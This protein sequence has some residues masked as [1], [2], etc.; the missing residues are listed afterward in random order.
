M[1]PRLFNQNKLVSLIVFFICGLALIAHVVFFS[2]Y[3]VDDAYISYRYSENFADGNG[4]VFNH[5]EKVEGYSNFLWVLL[6]GLLKKGSVDVILASK[7]IGL[8]S[9]L[10]VLIAYYLIVRDLTE[11]PLFAAASLWLLVTNFGLVFFS[12]TGMET[13]FFTAFILW[14]GYIFYRNKSQLT[15][16]LSLISFGVALTR[17]EGILFFPVLVV[18]D[19]I[20]NKRLSGKLLA[21]TGVFTGLYA[22]FLFWRYSYYGAFF[23]NTYYAKLLKV[24]AGFSQ[25]MYGFDD[26]YRFIASTGGP[27]MFAIAVV[28]LMKKKTRE[29]VYALLP[30]LAV[31]LIFQIYS[32]G[33]WMDSYRFLVPMLPAYL[34]IGL[35]GLWWL[36]N[37]IGVEGTHLVFLVVIAF[38]GLFN[39]GESVNFYVQRDKYPNFVMTSEDLIPAAEWVGEHYPSDYTIVCGRIGALPY[40]SRLN[41]IDT[42]WGLTD[43]YVAHS[44]H[45]GEWT[46]E[47]EEAYLRDRNPE[48]IM[49]STPRDACLKEKIQVGRRTYKLVRHFRQGS[50]QWWVLYERNDLTE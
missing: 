21:S 15:V 28:I 48:L 29:R 43:E 36:L 38:I 23:P 13:G 12:V 26:I 18:F 11:E 16:G 17:P 49:T 46:I 42:V 22:L 7:I 34:A 33:D 27:I 35:F 4:L 3:T 39:M 5:G 14:G 37:K 8:L 31:I 32:S 6:L 41:L 47:T 9:L 25:I 40:Y 19:L 50:E 2:R 10:A 1:R 20:K 30:I 44:K 45:R 24:S